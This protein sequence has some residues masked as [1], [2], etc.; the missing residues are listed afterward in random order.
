MYLCTLWYPAVGTQSTQR[1]HRWLL[2]PLAASGTSSGSSTV[3][4]KPSPLGSSLTTSSAVGGGTSGAGAPEQELWQQGAVLFSARALHRGGGTTGIFG[5]GHIGFPT[6]CFCSN[7]GTRDT[8]AKS[9]ATARGIHQ[10][11]LYRAQLH[12]L[13]PLSPSLANL[14]GARL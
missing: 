4:R 13:L 9:P 3:A 10:W 14:V 2:S 6:P 7:V 8:L 12:R 1:R 11:I 5:N